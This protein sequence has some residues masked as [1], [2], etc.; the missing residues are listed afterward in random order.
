LIR[1]NF[2]GGFERLATGSRVWY[3]VANVTD[4]VSQFG[5]RRN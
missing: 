5:R 3:P 4:F 2:I 1:T